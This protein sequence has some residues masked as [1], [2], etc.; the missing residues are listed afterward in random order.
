MTFVCLEAGE[1]DND[2]FCLNRD[3][4]YKSRNIV[5]SQGR[6]EGLSVDLVA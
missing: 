1:N 4:A 5:P 2:G 3:R 6:Q